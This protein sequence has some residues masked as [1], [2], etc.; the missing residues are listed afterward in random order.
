MGLA[1]AAGLIGL[2]LLIATGTGAGAMLARPVYDQPFPFELV[3]PD[4][5]EGELVVELCEGRPADPLPAVLEVPDDGIVQLGPVYAFDPY[6]SQVVVRRRSGAP[7]EGLQTGWQTTGGCGYLVFVVADTEPWRLPMGLRD[8]V[9]LVAD[10]RARGI[11]YAE[12]AR[13]DG[14]PMTQELAAVDWTSLHDAYGPATDA[15]THLRALLEGDAS[16]QRAA[17]SYLDGALLHQGTPF[18]AT[19]EA[20]RF[21]GRHLADPRVAPVRGELV[22][23]LAGVVE[24]GGALTDEELAAMALPDLDERLATLEDPYE[25][26]AV[27]DALYARSVGGCREVGEVLVGTPPDHAALVAALWRVAGEEAPE[28]EGAR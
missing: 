2:A 6:T 5:Y 11:S 19:P 24:A 17:V 18:T 3:V 8:P 16:A 27:A 26:V 9:D 28:P 15:P 22:G 14:D 23:F 13:L 21:V 4:G 10:A 1:W 20:A 12:A 25:D 7:A